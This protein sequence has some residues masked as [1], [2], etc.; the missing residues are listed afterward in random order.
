ML[1]QT[2]TV[3]SH[4]LLC[5]FCDFIIILYARDQPVAVQYVHHGFVSQNQ[6]YIQNHSAQQ[7][8]LKR[9]VMR[10]YKVSHFCIHIL[11]PCRP[12]FTLT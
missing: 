3:V 4:H 2:L 6:Q 10:R 8:S 9:M 1:K 12:R 11:A 7:D 5:P